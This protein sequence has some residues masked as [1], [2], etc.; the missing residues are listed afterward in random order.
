MGFKKK[1]NPRANGIPPSRNSQHL[2][3]AQTESLKEGN[4][5]GFVRWNLKTG[6]GAYTYIKRIK[7]SRKKRQT[8]NYQ[9]T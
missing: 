4:N 7:T 9:L 2:N 6:M 5:S 1:T 3:S 8:C